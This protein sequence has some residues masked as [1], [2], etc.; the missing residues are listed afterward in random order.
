MSKKRRPKVKNMS[1]P[2]AVFVAIVGCVLAVSANVTTSKMHRH[3]EQERYQRMLAESQ[4]QKA[5]NTIKA[6]KKE[7]SATQ[8]KIAGITQILNQGQTAAENLKSQLKGMAQEKDSLSQEIQ[9]LQSELNQQR[10]QA[11]PAANP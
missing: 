2:V 1:L 7:L 10:T 9:Q 6:L 4:L 5:D 8:D 11:A 3:L